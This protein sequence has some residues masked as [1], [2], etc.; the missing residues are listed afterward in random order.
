MP[1]TLDL[2]N[3][4]N[5]IPR[6]D[7]QRALFIKWKQEGDEQAKEELYKSLQPLIENQVGVFMKSNMSPEALKL[8][9]YRLTAQ[10]LKNYDPNRGV[11]VGTHVSNYLRK[12]YRFSSK[13]QNAGRIPE[14]KMM[15][16]PKYK[17]FVEEYHQEHG[18][19]PEIKDIAKA[20]KIKETEARDLKNMVRDDIQLQEDTS[21]AKHKNY[22][23]DSMT[24][25]DALYY[26][27]QTLH[28]KEKEMFDKIMKG[29]DFKQI[30]ADLGMSYM[31]AFRMK[32]R[33]TN[34]IRD[35]LAQIQ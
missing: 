16:V 28:G 18:K 19:P 1:N 23:H 25:E 15:L 9:A 8:E 12:L 31:Q 30:A 26:I 22:Y 24:I 14:H 7:K 20:L 4:H 35:R 27:G 13:Y 17:D 3:K 6:F 34:I 32:Q 29:E 11:G 5:K 33:L 21:M 10:A 2:N